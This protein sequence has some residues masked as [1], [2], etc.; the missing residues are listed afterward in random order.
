MWPPLTS[1]YWLDGSFQFFFRV[2][3]TQLEGTFIPKHLQMIN[4]QISTTCQHTFSLNAQLAAEELKKRKIIANSYFQIKLM[5]KNKLG[6][7]KEC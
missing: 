7:I 3:C 1:I 2:I 6:G 5:L 4:K